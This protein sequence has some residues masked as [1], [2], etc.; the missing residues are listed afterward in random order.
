MIGLFEAVHLAA[1]LFM[2][3]VIW[4]VQLVHYPMFAHVGPNF[5]DY[6][7]RYT[8]RVSWLVGP[9]MGVE[10]VAAVALWLRDPNGLLTVGLALLALIWCST[11]FVQVPLHGRLEQG[12]SPALGARLVRT[13]WW[14]TWAWSLRAG[15]LLAAYGVGL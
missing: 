6:H 1:T 5:C 13:N 3:G 11:A 12:Y 9:A 14:R 15:I 8:A 10:L 7:R 4:F 2:T